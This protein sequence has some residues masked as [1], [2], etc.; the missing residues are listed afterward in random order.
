MP[1]K[2]SESH[3]NQG[4]VVAQVILLLLFFL[5]QTLAEVPIT[6]RLEE[7]EG[8]P[9]TMDAEYE[10]MQSSK[11]KL[12]PVDPNKPRLVVILAEKKCNTPPSP[13]FFHLCATSF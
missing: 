4:S 6:F 7:A 10:R 3:W 8:L 1:E 5:L 9:T 13:S 11:K 2:K 12:K